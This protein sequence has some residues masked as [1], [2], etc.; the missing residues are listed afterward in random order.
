MTHS[1]S[2][3]GSNN[4]FHNDAWGASAGNGLELS[5]VDTSVGGA[6]DGVDETLLMKAFVTPGAGFPSSEAWASSM[7][8]ARRS[9]PLSRASQ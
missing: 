7:A 4:S 2:L 1:G 8:A 9:A 5:P 3:A 6:D